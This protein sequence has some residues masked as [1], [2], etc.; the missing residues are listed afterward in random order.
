MIEFS[1]E[2]FHNYHDR[3]FEDYRGTRFR[4][5]RYTQKVIHCDWGGERTFTWADFNKHCKLA[6]GSE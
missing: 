4:I 2:N 3:W 1:Y 6:R 5:L